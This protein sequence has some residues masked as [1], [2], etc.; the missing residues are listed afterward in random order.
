[1]DSVS[2]FLVCSAWCEWFPKCTTYVRTVFSY[3]CVCVFFF[4]WEKALS[5][6]DQ[7]PNSWTYNFV[8]VSGHNLESSHTLGF[9]CTLILTSLFRAGARMSVIKLI[10]AW[11]TISCCGLNETHRY[12]WRLQGF[13]SVNLVFLVAYRTFPGCSLT[14]DWIFP[15]FFE[16]RCAYLFPARTCPG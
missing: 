12:P 5:G 16:F 6:R 9:F 2:E 3:A 15:G 13:L 10:L 4:A 7:K 11:N 1:M 8:E 14:P